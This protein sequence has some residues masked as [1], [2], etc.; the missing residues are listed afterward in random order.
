MALIRQANAREIARDA[1]VLDL[2]DLAR[3]GEHLRLVARREAERILSEARAERD[4]LIATAAA[5]GREQGLKEGREQGI[6][7]G[8]TAGREAAL[9]EARAR[10]AQ[11]EKSFGD[12]LGAFE[13][14]R[15]GLLL[16]ARKDVLAFAVLAAEKITKRQVLLDRAIAT[17]Q[18]GA[19]LALL[20]K[21]TKLRIGVSA[22][23]EAMVKAA[24]PELTRRFGASEDIELIVDASLSRGSVVARTP[25]GGRLD[26]TIETQLA[27]MV[28]A[29]MPGAGTGAVEAEGTP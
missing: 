1:V 26:A 15:Q 18:V 3:Q 16:E 19:I 4:R 8:T 14:V 29:A 17:E 23:D 21:P 6:R 11:L 9:T 24:L 13:G 5:E 22:E 2:G 25:G 7:E 20:A 27:R 28:E 12:L 10:L